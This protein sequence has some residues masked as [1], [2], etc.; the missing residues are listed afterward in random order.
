L[1]TCP[2][3]LDDLGSAIRPN[4]SWAKPHCAASFIWF[5]HPE[6]TFK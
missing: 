3:L 5:I 2:D 6:I 4:L 1:R